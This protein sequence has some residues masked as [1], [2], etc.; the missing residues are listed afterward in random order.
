MFLFWCSCRCSRSCLCT[1]F[2]VCVGVCDLSRC[3]GVTDLCC[4]CF[5]LCTGVLVDVCW[6]FV[7]VF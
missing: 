4:R 6:M 5:S 3:V 2:F 1:L 7:L